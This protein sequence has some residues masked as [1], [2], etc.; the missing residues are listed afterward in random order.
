MYVR[1]LEA[2]DTID[3]SGLDVA[4]IVD[5]GDGADEVVGTSASD[6]ILGGRGADNL[7]GGDGRDLIVGGRDGDELDGGLA[8]DIVIGGEPTVDIATLD[9]ALDEWKSHNNYNNAVDAVKELLIANQNVIEDQVIDTLTGG[10]GRDLFFAASDTPS[11]NDALADLDAGQEQIEVTHPPIPA[12]ELVHEPLFA[13]FI[14]TNGRIDRVVLGIPP[15]LLIGST[16]DALS[17]SLSL[18]EVKINGVR[19]LLLDMNL[20]L[21]AATLITSEGPNGLAVIEFDV[22]TSPLGFDSLVEVSSTLRGPGVLDGMP[23]SFTATD[24]LEP[25]LH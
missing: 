5:A 2:S 14:D 16:P 21:S 25:V 4:A 23:E 19:V 18:M 20:F 7:A 9:A 6:L 3:L 11:N 22:E 13:I 8:N 15:A 24:E 12:S 10:A 17:V 1:G